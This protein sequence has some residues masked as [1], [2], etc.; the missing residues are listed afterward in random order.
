M[1]SVEQEAQEDP[2]QIFQFN[3]DGEEMEVGLGCDLLEAYERLRREFNSPEGIEADEARC[4]KDLDGKTRAFLLYG[5]NESDQTETIAVVG[6][7]PKGYFAS[8]QIVFQKTGNEGP[9]AYTTSF[10]LWWEHSQCKE[11]WKPAIDY[12]TGELRK[13]EFLDDF[14]DVLIEGFKDPQFF[15]KEPG[16]K[17]LDSKSRIRLL[18]SWEV[19]LPHTTSLL[20]PLPHFVE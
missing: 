6:V 14:E 20:P 12:K 4:L 10:K 11:P 17:P 13:R 19:S 9:K 18:S 15:E 1:K 16:M 2:S 7:T 5:Y 8:P 3:L